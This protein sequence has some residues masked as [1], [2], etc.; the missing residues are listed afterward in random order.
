MEQSQETFQDHLGNFQAIEHPIARFRESPFE[1]PVR[2]LLSAKTHSRRFDFTSRGDK[3]PTR[4][5]ELSTQT[6]TIEACD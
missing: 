6:V 2:R 5:A 1:G 3:G 4:F